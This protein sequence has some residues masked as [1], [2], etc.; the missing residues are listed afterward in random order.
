VIAV[1]PRPGLPPTP[2]VVVGLGRAGQASALAL[3]RHVGPDAV[4]A[5]DERKTPATLAAAQRLAAE[6]IATAFGERPASWPAPASVVKSPGVRIDAP[7]LPAGVPAID[8]LELGWRIADAPVV[9]VTGTNGKGTTCSLI[10][11]VLSS[12]GMPAAFCGNFEQGQPL[13]ATTVPPGGVLVVEASSFQ[14]EG[15]DALL[16]EVAVLTNIGYDHRDRHGSREAYQAIKRRMFVRG[17]RT[18]GAAVL[19]AD[20]DFGRDLASELR[21]L[22]SNVVTFGRSESSDY[23][24]RSLDFGLAES[25]AVLSTPQGDVVLRTRLPG[26]HNAL[27]AT[28]ALAA[29][30][31]FGVGRADC[32]EA[33]AQAPAVPGRFQPIDAGQPFTA[34][35]DFAHN[36]EGYE[37]VLD[38][39]RRL[40][41]GSLRVL[42]GA[43]GGMDQFKRPPMGLLAA[44]LADQVVVTAS[45]VRAEE[46]RDLGIC[47]LLDGMRAGAAEILV[48]RDRLRA[49]EMLVDAAEPGDL[50]LV[51]GRGAERRPLVEG[52]D[53]LFDDR[54]ALHAALASR[55]G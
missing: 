30:E 41:S 5:F 42:I 13:S 8:E 37:V 3:A 38:C 53:E 18:A 34:I 44:T 43:R 10:A 39:A 29:A 32:L 11:H 7:C 48:E 31:A 23:R 15:T 16:P 6:G 22:E 50:I 20:Y 24:V 54:E 9:A 19:P 25:E 51:L 21:A 49:I 40:T 4:Y 1:A 36:P 46:P 14:L 55:W 27:N 12:A 28:A 2:I 26:A 35:V 52:D 33:L 17:E 45:D 47:Q